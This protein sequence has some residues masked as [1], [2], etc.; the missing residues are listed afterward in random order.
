M[1]K[2]GASSRLRE[3]AAHRLLPDMGVDVIGNQLLLLGREG[4]GPLRPGYGDRADGHNVR[5]SPVSCGR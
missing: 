2:F 1:V 3:L 4:S 5:P